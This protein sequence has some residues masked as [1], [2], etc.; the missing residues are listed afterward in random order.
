VIATIKDYLNIEKEVEELKNKMEDEDEIFLVYKKL[1]I[2]TFV[3]M[4]LV[5]RI[6]E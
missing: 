6:E 3:R 5:K 1:K 4:T 2:M